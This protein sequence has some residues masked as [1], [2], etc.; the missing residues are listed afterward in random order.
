MA[1]PKPPHSL[2]HPALSHLRTC[3]VTHHG[4]LGLV[5]GGVGSAVGPDHAIDAKLAVIGGVPKVAA[6]RPRL[7][8]AAIRGSHRVQ[9]ALVDPVPYEAALCV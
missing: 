9:Q 3:A 6:V 5:A 8:L 1:M 7:D 2:R 4:D